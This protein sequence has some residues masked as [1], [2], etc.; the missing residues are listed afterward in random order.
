MYPAL[1]VS[2]PR[3]PATAPPLRSLHSA[4]NYA[5]LLLQRR[6]VALKPRIKCAEVSNDEIGGSKSWEKWLPRNLF[7]AEK[8]FGAISGATSSP[9]AQYI[10]SPTTFLHSV[11]P[12]IKLAWLLAFVVLPAKADMTVRVGVVVY[13]ALLSVWVQPT[14]VWKDQL[15]RVTLLCGILFVLLG[16][17]TDSAPS[18]L[19]SRSP[20]SSV[21]GLPNLAASYEGYKYVIMKFGPLQL[22][23]KG[24]SAATTAACL[25]FTIFQSA[26]LCLTTTT[27]EQLAFALQW[28]IL[29]LKNCG[30]PVAEVILTLLLS[31]RFIN[32]VFDEVRNVALGIVSRRI[33]WEQLTTLETVDV[34][35]T[36]IRRIFKNVYSH[37]EQISQA[38]IVRGFRGDCNSY[39]IF[40]SA[41]SST[42]IANIISCS[43]L[44]G[45]VCATTLPRF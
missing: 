34:F 37:A 36:Y 17:S 4:R 15:G 1:L 6:S 39:R 29:P 21:T 11:D 43:C 38:M 33:Q 3:P 8:V 13:L 27:S 19:R 18:L 5:Q 35:F 42:K 22:T 32:L 31:L 9:I 20:P 23:S 28:F 24:L 7:G 44:I 16:L 30:V 45:L 25:T 2:H 14:E 26:S 10:S 12:R 41:G 40:L